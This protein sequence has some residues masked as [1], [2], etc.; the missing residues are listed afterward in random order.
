[1]AALTT[2]AV[3]AEGLAEEL[4]MPLANKDPRPRDLGW[5]LK[6][7][8]TKFGAPKLSDESTDGD[9]GMRLNMGIFS[10]HVIDRS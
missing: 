2:L 8:G 5:K 4:L 6:S 3:E 9:L 10:S 1:M 7:D